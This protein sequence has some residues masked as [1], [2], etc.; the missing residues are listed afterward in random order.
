[1]V[2]ALALVAGAA[3]GLSACTVEVGSR[4]TST[5]S[6]ITTLTQSTETIGST[7]TTI[8]GGGT[9]A[10]GLASPAEAVAVKLGPSVVN[11]GRED[12]GQGSGVIYS[13]DGMIITNNHVITDDFGNPVQGLEVTFATGDKLPATVV[14]RDPLTDLAVIRVTATKPLPAAV[15]AAALPAVGEYAVAIGSPAG[16]QNSVTLGI[17]S[18]L[19]RSIDVPS[20]NGR[21]ETYTGLIQTDTP[22]SG[23]NSGG[24]LANAEGVVIGVNSAGLFGSTVENIGFAIPSVVVTEVADEIISSGK[25]THA[26]MGI[27]PTTVSVD[28]QRQFGLSRSSGVLVAEVTGGGPADKAGMKQGDIIVKIDDK[29]MVESSDVLAA[30]RDKKPGDSVQ[31]TIDREGTTSVISVTLEERPAGQ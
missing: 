23:G 13:S 2:V 17:V 25:A 4:T 28:L 16:F 15:F 30:I 31:V 7:A 19:D 22:I 5:A 1:M 9:G 8:A 14:G 24:A 3:F 10:D 12:G 27:G 20:G 21:V 11:I 29:E 6:P 26:F 18:A